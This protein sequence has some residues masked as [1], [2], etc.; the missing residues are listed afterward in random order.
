MKKAFISFTLCLVV[1][2]CPAQKSKV[3]S[4]RLQD[5]LNREYQ[6]AINRFADSAVRTNSLFDFR[7][8][9]RKRATNEAYGFIIEAHDAYLIQLFNEWLRKK[10]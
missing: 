3:D 7:E 10:K 8:W 6:I 4:A 2:I 1:S 5:S 9:A